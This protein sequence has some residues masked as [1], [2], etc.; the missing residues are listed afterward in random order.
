MT[1]QIAR[2]TRS[3][4]L[5]V[6]SSDYIRTA[7]SQGIDERTITYKYALRNVAISVITVLGLQ[8][9][10]LL[11]GAIIT[12]TVF[13]W[14]G[15]GRLMVGAIM[16]RDYPLLQGTILVF[17]A[18]YIFINLLVDLSYGFIDPRVSEQ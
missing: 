18:S 11:G 1:P 9:G 2:L 8:I 15:L 3:G 5:D 16:D 6:L 14:P 10:T 12:E 7:K 13:A 4:V 17:A